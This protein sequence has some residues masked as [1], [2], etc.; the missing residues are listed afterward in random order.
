MSEIADHPMY[1][2]AV[3]G[4]ATAILHLALGA[5]EAVREAAFLEACRR[6]KRAAVEAMVAHGLAGRELRTKGLE[7]AVPHEGDDADV[8]R[9]RNNVM[10]L[11]I[12]H[13]ADPSGD[14]H[15]ALRL[16]AKHG[17]LDAVRLLLEFGADPAAIDD[18]APSADL[19]RLLRASQAKRQG[20]PKQ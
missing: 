20:I 8:I 19:E 5:P 16:A 2:A 12:K 14:A 4:D 1:R 15:A 10:R 11:L 17:A 13:G 6:G 18:A 3:L 7:A 9:R